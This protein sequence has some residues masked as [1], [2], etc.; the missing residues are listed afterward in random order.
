M[1]FFTLDTSEIDVFIPF[2]F[3]YRDHF[4]HPRYGKHV[5]GCIYVFFIL[6]RYWVRRGVFQ[7][8]GT[9]LLMQFFTLGS[10]KIAVF[11]ICF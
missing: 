10:S 8:I 7:E 6:I 1:P 9:H 5:S 11:E 2:F 3:S 4:D